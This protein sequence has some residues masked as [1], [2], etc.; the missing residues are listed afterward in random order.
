MLEDNKKETVVIAKGDFP[1]VFARAMVGLMADDKIDP[2]T[3]MVV[4][5]L[6][7][8]I[9]HAIE[10]ELFKIEEQEKEENV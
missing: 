9:G 10:D 5:M 8:I 1:N 2:E 7:T 3:K 4:M 6:G